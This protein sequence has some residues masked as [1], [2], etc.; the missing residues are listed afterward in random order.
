MGF[1]TNLRKRIGLGG[2]LFLY[3]LFRAVPFLLAIF[4]PLLAG[5][6]MLVADI[7]TIATQLP[8]W[9][10]LVTLLFVGF[11]FAGIGTLYEARLNDMAERDEA[12]KAD[13]AESKPI[14]EQGDTKPP[15]ATDKDNPPCVRKGCTRNG[16]IPSNP[17]CSQCHSAWIKQKPLRCAKCGYKHTNRP[18]CKHCYHK[19]RKENEP[20]DAAATT[21]AGGD[22]RSKYPAIHRTTDGHFV[23][24][25]AE[26]LI[27]NYLYAAGIA[28]TYERKLP[29]AAEDVY[30]DFYL[31]D[32]DVYIEYWGRNDPEY[33]RNKA[34]KLAVYKKHN[35]NLIELHDT[36]VQNL[37]D[38]LP[39][40]LRQ[41]GIT[42]A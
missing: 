24:S 33:L 28:H 39:R 37:D 22:F 23:R 4:V 20:A 7:D 29:M 11:A 5:A 38:H 17:L 3:G 12:A 9:T 42:V 18:L 41:F 35:L 10:S 21:S 27:D 14:A 8:D 30:C 13:K 36:E 26:I 40:L 34:R 15:P 25:K 2:A 19:W 6:K 1:F 31:P 32:K 16:K